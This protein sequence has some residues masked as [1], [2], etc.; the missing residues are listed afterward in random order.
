MPRAATATAT[1]EST[2]DTSVVSQILDSPIGPITIA[3]H[4]GVLTHVVMHDQRHAPAQQEGWALDVDGELDHV[5]AQLGEYFA[6]DRTE[7]DVALDLSAG[8]EFQQ[9]VWQ[10]LREIPYGETWSYGELAR[11]IGSP[12]ASRAVGL[13]NGRNPISIIVPCHRVI[14]ADGS[15]IGYGGGL[16]RKQTLLSLESPTLFS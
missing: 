15:L 2:A 10:A 4:D 9:R 8:T 16:D 5:A 11:H 1:A 3:G 12:Q 6:G 13:A 7:F 14:G